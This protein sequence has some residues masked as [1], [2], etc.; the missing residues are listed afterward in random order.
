M[1]KYTIGAL[2]AMLCKELDEA[3]VRGIKTHE[4]LDIVKDVAETLKNL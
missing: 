2:K 4:D 3:V 1:D